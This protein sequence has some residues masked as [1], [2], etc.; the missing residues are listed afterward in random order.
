MATTYTDILKLAKPQTGDLDGVWGT[1]VNN[2]ITELV[3]EAIAGLAVIDNWVNNEITLASG[4]GTNVNNSRN[5]ILSIRNDNTTLNDIGTVNIPDSSKVY[6][7]ENT[8]PYDVVFT[9]GIVSDPAKTTAT[10]DAGETGIIFCDG[11]GNVSPAA[12]SLPTDVVIEGTL[13]VNGTL[14]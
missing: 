6:L 9:T 12:G 7:I 8:T 11:G 4:D 2:E 1:E 13:D 10:V 3:E 14:L 5:A